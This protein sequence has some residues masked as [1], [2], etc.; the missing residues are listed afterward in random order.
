MCNLFRTIGLLVVILLLCA[1]S[2]E[3]M[4]SEKVVQEVDPIRPKE[5]VRMEEKLSSVEEADKFSFSTVKESLHERGCSEDTTK[6]FEKWLDL[7]PAFQE[8]VQDAVIEINAFEDGRVRLRFITENNNRFSRYV[9]DAPETVI[10]QLWEVDGQVLEGASG[11][12]DSKPPMD[13]ALVY[14]QVLAGFRLSCPLWYINL[15]ELN[16]FY[17]ID[18]DNALGLSVGCTAENSNLNVYS[19]GQVTL[20]FTDECGPEILLHIH[21][22][23]GD[24]KYLGVGVG[25][26]VEDLIKEL[27]QDTKNVEPWI[28]E[29]PE[30]CVCRGSA[31]SL[32]FKETDGL[33][34]ELW[35]YA[36]M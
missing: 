24:A 35:L 29:Y 27:E 7:N 10:Y 28:I 18:T 30:R 19:N 23:T 20:C 15:D 36:Y 14:S 33:I 3:I 32:E 9:D 34:T 11:V 2:P 26:P 25:D 12:I 21:V 17:A 16:G 1:C 13:L 6:R 22:H 5:N 8:K 31:F 4:G